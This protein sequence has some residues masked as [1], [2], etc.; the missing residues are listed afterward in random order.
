VLFFPRSHHPFHKFKH[1]ISP[2][3]LPCG[4]KL[5][6]FYKKQMNPAYYKHLL[7]SSA[8]HIISHAKAKMLIILVS[9]EVTGDY[10]FQV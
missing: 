9:Y 5:T 7:I 8:K 1:F 2:H 6:T 4:N 3:E 10:T